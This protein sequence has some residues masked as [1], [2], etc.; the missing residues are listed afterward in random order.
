M[1]KS[2]LIMQVVWKHTV[3]RFS[4]VISSL[5]YIWNNFMRWHKPRWPRRYKT[6]FLLFQRVEFFCKNYTNI[7]LLVAP[8]FFVQLVA[9]YWYLTYF[10]EPS[11]KFMWEPRAWVGNVPP[12]HTHTVRKLGNFRYILIPEIINMFMTNMS[13]PVRAKH[14]LVFKLNLK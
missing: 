2:H 5:T 14:V 12:P 7:L 3:K 1:S 8:Y 10:E 9:P 4:F 6:A 11:I 13:D